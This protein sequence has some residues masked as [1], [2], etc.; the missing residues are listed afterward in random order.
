MANRHASTPVTPA[1]KQMAKSCSVTA[2]RRCS[3]SLMGTASSQR[4]NRRN[5]TAEVY[6][7]RAAA[8]QLAAPE[9]FL[10]IGLVVVLRRALALKPPFHQPGARER[11]LV[12][13]GDEQPARMF[14]AAV[15]QQRLAG[16]E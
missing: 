1:M 13:A 6:R 16:I 10:A 4:A 5:N 8:A 3:G 11:P 14:S 12:L 2:C 15:L 9:P 7:T